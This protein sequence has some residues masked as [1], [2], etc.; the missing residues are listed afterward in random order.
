[1]SNVKVL[2]FPCWQ[3]VEIG[4]SRKAISKH[5][6]VRKRCFLVCLWVTFP[7]TFLA[8]EER[9]EMYNFK[10]MNEAMK[11]RP[12][13]L[14]LV[15]K[16][17]FSYLASPTLLSWKINPSSFCSQF[18]MQGAMSAVSLNSLPFYTF[19]PAT[20]CSR[21]LHFPCSLLKNPSMPC[22]P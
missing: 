8:I 16:G 3:Q 9:L 10:W 19:F 4:S 5:G 15:K 6:M 12:P 11:N 14:F 18:Q 7:L 22:V 1:M 13:S 17:N 20:N 2:I 21:V